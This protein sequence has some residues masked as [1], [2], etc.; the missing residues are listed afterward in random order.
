[1]RSSFCFR[2]SSGLVDFERGITAVFL[3]VVIST[4]VI[5]KNGTNHL[6][7]HLSQPPSI[8]SEPH[9]F[10]HIL[11]PNRTTDILNPKLL[12]V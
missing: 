8:H 4:I 1:M 5:N 7:S 12:M 3:F 11:G 6:S 2:L 10:L 9:E